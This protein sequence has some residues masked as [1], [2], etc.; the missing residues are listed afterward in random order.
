MQMKK[1]AGGPRIYMCICMYVYIYIYIYIFF[2]THTIIVCFRA[3]WP[4]LGSQIGLM[5][6]FTKK[7]REGK[8]EDGTGMG[9][10]TF[11]WADQNIHFLEPPPKSVYTFGGLN[12]PLES[13]F[14]PP[15]LEFGWLN[16]APKFNPPKGA[17]FLGELKLQI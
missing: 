1:R 8:G 13:K 5:A 17:K 15:N 14:S 4:I 12:L 7:G 11:G 9:T 3:G 6:H 2:Y 10:K 16:L